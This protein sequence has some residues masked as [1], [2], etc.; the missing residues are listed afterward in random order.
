MSLPRPAPMPPAFSIVVPCYRVCA[1]RVLVA[2]CL[3][4]VAAQ[5]CTDFELLLIDDG[6]KDGT[7]ELLAR[8]VAGFPRLGPR[9]RIVVLPENGGVCAARNAG[10]DAARGDFIA[11][12]DFDDLWQPGYLARVQE[13]IRQHP[14]TPV[15]LVRTDFMRT[16]GSTL[17]ARGSGS[18]G[19]LND[20]DDLDFGAWHLLHDFPVAMGSAVVVSRALYVAQPDLRFDLAL[21]RTTAEDVLFGLTLLA[22]GIRPR[23]VDEALCI[24]RRVVG[25]VSRGTAAFLWGDERRVN[26]YIAERAADQITRRVVAERPHLAMPLR[27]RRAQ[28][29]LEFDLKA[30]YLRPEHW[31]GLKRCLARPRGLKTLVRLMVMH[32]VAGTALDPLLQR[33]LFFRGGDDPA[34]RARVASLLRELERSMAPT[35]MPAAVPA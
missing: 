31:F 25:S 17:R 32:A 29:D 15:F 6:S 8:E 34:A 21:T 30:Q 19:H 22:R 26:D 7:A 33:Y 14:L 23:Y 2:Q 28:L 35:T 5:T 24:H 13:S 11:F 9:S 18:I 12:L 27:R 4:S 3:A 1:Q 10:I 20:L 16:L